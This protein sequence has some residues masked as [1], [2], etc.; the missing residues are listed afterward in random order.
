MAET[1]PRWKAYVVPLLTLAVPGL[2]HWFLGKRARAAAFCSIVTLTFL[3]GIALHGGLFPVT[4]PNWL[5][6]LG[7]VAQ[8]GLGS[9]YV[10]GRAMGWGQLGLLDMAD[11]M[12]GYGN[13]FLVTAGLMNMLLIMDAFDIAVGR[14]E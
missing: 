5:F 11:V 7:G 10:L 12:F 14:K 3:S 6:R 8:L 13:T 9:L 4:S 2:A 1:F